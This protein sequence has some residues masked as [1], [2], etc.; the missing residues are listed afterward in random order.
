MKIK[1]SRLFYHPRLSVTTH[2][3]WY[4]LAVLLFWSYAERMT[5]RIPLMV[6]P[7]SAYIQTN[8]KWNAYQKRTT[9]EGALPQQ[10]QNI[11]AAQQGVAPLQQLQN[12]RDGVFALI[13][14]NGDPNAYGKG[15]YW[16]A[17]AEAV[18]NGGGDCDEYATLSYQVLRRL[19]YDPVVVSLNL[20]N[21]VN[22]G[23]AV[24]FVKLDGNVY[25]LDNEEQKVLP[26]AEWWQY[27]MPVVS[28]YMDESGH[29]FAFWSWTSPAAITW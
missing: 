25:V 10:L 27:S 8:A 1:V 9:A 6:A 5:T 12:V 19:G 18:A 17:P 13:A 7:H 28:S 22:A 16:A 15:D 20:F 23:H 24:T 14:P 26:I 4:V 21:D 11:I 2:I 29:R 3:I